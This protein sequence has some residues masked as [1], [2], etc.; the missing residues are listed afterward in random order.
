MAGKFQELYG[1]TVLKSLTQRNLQVDI[2]A[3]YDE[4]SKSV[5]ILKLWRQMRK[6][7]VLI[8][9]PSWL[10]GGGVVGDLA[11]FVAAS[12]G[13]GRFVPIQ[14]AVNHTVDAVLAKSWY[15]SAWC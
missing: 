5:G 2:M 9:K 6:L 11:G 8:V 13:R 4:S 10:L 15:Q 14:T 3:T 1:E 7:T 12:Y